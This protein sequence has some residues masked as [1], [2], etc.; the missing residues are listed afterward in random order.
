VQTALVEAGRLE[1]LFDDAALAALYDLTG[2]VARQVARLADFALLAGAA[3]KL[4]SI[5]VATI[6]AAHDEIAWPTAAAAH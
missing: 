1:P 3:A 6:E 4:N 5:D 2:G